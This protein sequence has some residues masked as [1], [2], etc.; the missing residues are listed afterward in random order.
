MKKTI[1]ILSLSLCLSVFASGQTLTKKEATKIL[2]RAWDD[3]K[4]SDT[5]DFVKLWVLDD[6]QW[7]YHG[8]MKFGAAQVMQNY[9]DFKQYLDEA[10]L[11]KLKFDGVQCDTLEHGDPH[12]DYARYYIK[13]WFKLEDGHMRGFGFFM[14]YVNKQWMV[15][16]SPDYVD[17]AGKK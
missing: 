13:A 16:F 10:I 15:R 11:K 3:V 8:G 5:A 17:I 7:P 14:Q 1:A 2:Q 4:K 6:I 12:Y 9:A